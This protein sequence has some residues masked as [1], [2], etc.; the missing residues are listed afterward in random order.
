MSMKWGHN[1][2][3][4]Q[5]RKEEMEM[6]LLQI[7]SPLSRAL[8]GLVVTFSLALSSSACRKEEKA[9][10]SPEAPVVEVVEVTRQDVPIYDEW[11][12]TLDGMVNASIRAQVSGY[13]IKQNYRDGDLVKKGQLLFEID[14]RPFEAAL[15]QAQGTLDQS[16][17]SLDQAIAGVDI[18]D[19]R[20]GIA[21]ANLARV[22]PLAE[23]NAV[24]QKDL[25][26]AIGAEQSTRAS[27][28]A[29][30]AAVLAARASV[31]A[32]QANVEKA[33]LDLGFTR[34]ISP[35]EGIA[36]IAKA[37]IG[38]LVGPG[39]TE[40]LTT[41]SAVDPIKVYVALSEQEYLRAAETQR[42]EREEISLEMI[43]SGG[44]V[45]PHKGEIAFADRHVDVKTGTIRVAT[46]F[47]N[48]GNMLR[49]GQF[50][51]LRAKRG[52]KRGACVIPQRAVTEV[53]GK[54]L[55]TVVG[56]ENKAAIRPVKVG[57]RFGQL[58]VVDEGL[59]AGEKVV[60]EGTQ[61]VREGMVVSPKPFV[62]KAK[63]EP[64]AVQKPGSKPEVKSQPKKENG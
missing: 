44:S 40:E 5:N 42:S 43:L 52:V 11:V 6:R 26:D 3:F 33:K 35:I 53:Q 49:P 56:P 18:Q 38:D 2:Y 25:D 39:S 4:V 15:S 55:V 30:K 13:L 8:I 63:E 9:A 29:A 28:L 10:G 64:A 36:G 62:E 14:P 48:P 37:Q 17:G 41:V 51:R 21:K 50:A 1:L 22:R 27:V 20:W 24:S 7:Y 16:R 60:V 32:A 31:T 46:V 58:W 19:A 23:Q 45:Y 34:I 61:K 59:E 54:Y 12:G 47:P 57:E